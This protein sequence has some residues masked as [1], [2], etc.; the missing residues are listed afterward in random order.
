MA[1]VVTAFGPHSPPENWCMPS[2]ERGAWLF[3]CVLNLQCVRR[4]ANAI[5]VAPSLWHFV[6][7]F[8]TKSLSRRRGS[9]LRGGALS[10]LARGAT[11]QRRR[12]KSGV[13]APRDQ[14]GLGFRL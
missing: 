1:A 7:L 8:L 9:V 5:S 10:K 11:L 2:D 6:V 3:P 12:V 14:G 4:E 13:P